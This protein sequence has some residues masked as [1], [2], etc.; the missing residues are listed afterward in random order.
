VLRSGKNTLDGLSRR[1]MMASFVRSGWGR[2]DDATAVV[3]EAG[4]T[5]VDAH[6]PHEFAEAGDGAMSTGFGSLSGGRWSST[7]S[8]AMTNSY[9][10]ISRCAVSGCGRARH[11]DIHRAA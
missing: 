2:I 3:H 5:A 11:D 10:R 4:E 7:G 8:L 9:L 1:T 6:A